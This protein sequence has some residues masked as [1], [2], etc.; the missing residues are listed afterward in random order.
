MAQKQDRLHPSSSS[1][2]NSPYQNSDPTLSGPYPS[3][4]L[5]RVPYP[6][7]NGHASGS[8]SVA[9]TTFSL[10]PAHPSSNTETEDAA[11]VLED[12]ALGGRRPYKSLGINSEVPTRAP[13]GPTVIQPGAFTSIFVPF[14]ATVPITFDTASLIRALPEQK[15]AQALVGIYFAE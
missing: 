8:G 13:A 12:L 5:A 7:S 1:I 10:P 2:S 15:V 9:P 14:S 4:S 11:Q 3:H 6:A